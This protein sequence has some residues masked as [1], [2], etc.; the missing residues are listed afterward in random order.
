MAITRS[1]LQ[2][3]TPSDKHKENRRELHPLPHPHR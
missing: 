3:H 2:G 1:L